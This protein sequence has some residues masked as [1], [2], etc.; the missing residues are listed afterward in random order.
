MTDWYRPP[1]ADPPDTEFRETLAGGH[2]L[3]LEYAAG[4]AL[5]VQ[6]GDCA[7]DMACQCGY[8]ITYGLRPDRPWTSELDR[9]VAHDA[10]GRRTVFAHCQCG[11]PLGSGTFT[12][13]VSEQWTDAVCGNWEKHTMTGLGT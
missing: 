5:V 7:F 13:V 11:V 10:A 3:V 1:A 12:D 8:W 9:W 4:H 2:A 6:Y